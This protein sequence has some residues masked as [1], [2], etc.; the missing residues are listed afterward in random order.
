MVDP[1]PDRRRGNAVGVSGAE[2]ADGGDPDA[3]GED[4]QTRGSDAFGR[5]EEIEADEAEDAAC[6][7]ANGMHL[8]LLSV[9]SD[10]SSEPFRRTCGQSI[11]G[12]PEFVQRRFDIG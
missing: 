4:R 3:A 8:Q 5:W 12:S 10:P 6:S 7:Q 1:D 11:D 2:H 9:L